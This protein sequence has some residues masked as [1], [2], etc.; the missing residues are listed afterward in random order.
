MNKIDYN[1]FFDNKLNKEE[2]VIQLSLIAP[3]KNY[4]F[5][6]VC[7]GIDIKDTFNIIVSKFNNHISRSKDRAEISDIEIQN[8]YIFFKISIEEGKLKKMR[9]LIG[10]TLS[11]WLYNEQKWSLLVNDTANG[12]KLFHLEYKVYKS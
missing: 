4:D 8:K 5:N 2:F 9:T 7:E 1:M 3:K 12:N 6:Q 11:K 10:N